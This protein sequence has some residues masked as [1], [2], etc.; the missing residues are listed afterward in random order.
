M[1]YLAGRLLDVFEEGCCCCCPSQAL[2]LSQGRAQ[3]RAALQGSRLWS[4]LYPAQHRCRVQAVAGHYDP[5]DVPQALV[6]L[7]SR[8]TPVVM[9]LL[10]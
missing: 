4:E 3:Q 8:T 9:E 6:L 1:W 2:S 7:L 10:A 5:P